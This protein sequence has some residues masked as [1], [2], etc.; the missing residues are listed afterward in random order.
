M[1]LD[2]MKVVWQRTHEKLASMEPALRLS[3]R[4]ARESTLDRLR[5]KLRW[6]YG[7]LLIEIAFGVT[8]VLLTGSYL[9]DHIGAFRFAAPA[10]LL[11]LA[12]IATIGVAVWQLATLGRLDYGGPVLEIQRRL[13][14]LGMVRARAN[15]WTL[16]TAPLLWAALVVVVPHALIGLDVYRAFGLPWTLGN[17]AFGI[18]VLAVAFWASRKFPSWY[19]S[20]RLIRGLGDDLTGRRL[21]AASG[22]LRELADFERSSEG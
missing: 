5:A 10:A 16:F 2:E 18:L 7:A 9:A 6:T 17:L 14:E 1:E 21:A 15:R 22:Y 3:A 19:R 20:S 4:V 8:A 13:A 12:A 11:H